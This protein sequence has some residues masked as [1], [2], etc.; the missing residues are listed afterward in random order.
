[1]GESGTLTFRTSNVTLEETGEL[2][3]AGLAPGRYVACEV[4][5]TGAGM[6][7]GTRQHAFEPFFTTKSTGEG[8]GLGLSMVYGTI[9]NHGGQVI[10]SS[11]PGQGASFMIYLPALESRARDSES[12]GSWEAVAP[13]WGGTILLVDDEELVRT[14]GRRQLE[15]L[16]YKVLLAENGE[17]AL[18]R[19]RAHRQEID[20]VIL[21]LIMPVMNGVETFRKLRELDPKVRVLPS[22]GYS[23]RRSPMRS[24]PSARWASSRSPTP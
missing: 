6:D 14:S 2:Q 21:D 4:V 5:D 16:G 13:Q 18:T 19:Y 22:S 17:V 7:E 23:H 15:K 9:K 20:L 12:S 3:V 24:S 11:E 10:L 8:T 1:M